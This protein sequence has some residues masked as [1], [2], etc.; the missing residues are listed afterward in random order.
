[1]EP[2][3]RFVFGALNC[4]SLFGL[5]GGGGGIDN[6]EALQQSLNLVRES[7]DD[8]ATEQD[9]LTEIVLRLGLEPTAKIRHSNIDGLSVWDIEEGT[10]VAY[11]NEHQKPVLDQL[12]SVVALE[13][14]KLVVI[15]DSFK[16]DDQLKTNL[17]QDCKSK[18]IDL[19]TV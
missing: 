19:W 2:I 9:L 3:G 15:E 18:N 4:Q 10:V 16:G 11:L 1:L 17:V 12:R 13:P 6:K 8:S 5:G 7:S 14:A